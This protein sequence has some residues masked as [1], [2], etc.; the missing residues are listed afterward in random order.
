MTQNVLTV[1][2]VDYLNVVP[3]VRRSRKSKRLA[4]GP[5]GMTAV[6]NNR[7]A[8]LYIDKASTNCTIGAL[9]H[10]AVVVVSGNTGGGIQVYG[11]NTRVL[12]TRVGEQKSAVIFFGWVLFLIS[13]S[14]PHVRLTEPNEIELAAAQVS[15]YH[16]FPFQALAWTA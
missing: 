5:D 4:T 16:S 7:L 1:N 6:P 10:D 2:Q 8:A 13:L 12:N 3:V 14:S 11:A 9:G 15:L